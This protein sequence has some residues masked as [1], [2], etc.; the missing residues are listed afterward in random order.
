M[1]Q[2]DELSVCPIPSAPFNDKHRMH[3]CLIAKELLNRDLYHSNP[4][5]NLSHLYLRFPLCY[6]YRLTTANGDLDLLRFYGF[7]KT[8]DNYIAHAYSAKVGR[9]KYVVDDP[10][11]KLETLIRWAPE[12]EER[13]W[14]LGNR[15]VTD[16]FLDPCGFYCFVPPKNYS[17][18]A[19][20]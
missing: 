2:F 5:T 17:G 14:R 15:R 19:L 16:A 3:R 8:N 20:N 10:N 7:G 9:T 1:H 11:F 18:V 6:F 13:L 4:P 12:D